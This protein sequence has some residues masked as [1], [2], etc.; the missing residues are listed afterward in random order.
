MKVQ[1]LVQ[2]L[3]LQGSRVDH[4]RPGDWQSCD[5]DEE[6]INVNIFHL[7]SVYVIILSVFPALSR[8]EFSAEL[9]TT[10]SLAPLSYSRPG[11]GKY[12]HILLLKLILQMLFIFTYPSIRIA[13]LSLYENMKKNLFSVWLFLTQQ[14][15]W[16][17]DCS[18]PVAERAR[19]MK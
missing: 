2:V 1:Q 15:D 11:V 12:I 19:G 10:C 3:C 7:S 5:S 14:T 8:I 18:S 9:I 13:A 17:E 4:L 16:R 6:K